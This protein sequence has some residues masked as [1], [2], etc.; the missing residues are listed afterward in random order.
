MSIDLYVHILEKPE[1]L[2]NYPKFRQIY[3]FTEHDC[4]K[5]ISSFT[6]KG[7]SVVYQKKVIARDGNHVNALAKSVNDIL[8]VANNND[9]LDIKSLDVVLN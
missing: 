1:S 8:N 5:S 2:N 7:F 4:D 6:E 3:G 9:S